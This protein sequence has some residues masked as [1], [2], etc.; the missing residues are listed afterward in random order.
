MVNIHS[1]LF[2]TRIRESK[3]WGH[4]T[5]RKRGEGWALE[6]YEAWDDNQKSYG[7][8]NV[9]H[10]ERQANQDQVRVIIA[11]YLEVRES[12]R[13]NYEDQKLAETAE[14]QSMPSA[15]FCS[16]S[17]SLYRAQGKL[18]SFVKNWF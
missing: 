5:A 7:D 12:L 8:A 2:K 17:S 3:D 10:N 18:W 4:R 16:S 11:A 14:V 15:L 6:N 13:A 1:N 9:W